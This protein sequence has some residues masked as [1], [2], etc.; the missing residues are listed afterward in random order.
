MVYM[1]LYAGGMAYQADEAEES[2][3]MNYFYGHDGVVPTEILDKEKEYYFASAD[4]TAA[5]LGLAKERIVKAVIP[6]DDRRM[7]MGRLDSGLEWLEHLKQRLRDAPDKPAFDAIAS[8]SYKAWHAVKIIPAAAE[9]YAVTDGIQDHIDWMKKRSPGDVHLNNLEKLNNQ[10]K[11]KFLGLL[12]LDECADFEDS[13]QD[14]VEA[15]RMAAEAN[16][17]VLYMLEHS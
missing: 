4:K 5:R 9:G 8:S 14:R 10:A 17:L 11:A 3:L 13:E 7:L 12:N 1:R 2:S 6:E 15:Y 16:K